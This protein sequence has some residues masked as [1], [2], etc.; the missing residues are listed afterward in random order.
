MSPM[1][2]AIDILQAETNIQMGWLLPTLTQLKAKLDRIK[3]SLKF[4]KPLVDAIQLGLKNR[5]SEI[6]EDPELIAAA[7]LL[8]KFKTLWTKDETVLKKGLDYINLELE[9]VHPLSNLQ[10]TSSDD[11]DFFS[12]IKSNAQESSK[13]LEGYLA[14]CA[15]HTSLLKTFPSLC[16]LF[17]RLNTPLPASAAL[18]GMPSQFF[19]LLQSEMSSLNFVEKLIV[20][21]N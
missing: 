20:K 9:S 10:A 17:I 21:M 3:P 13:E 1:A 12:S 16:K 19:E 6:L 8:P 4:S 14:C 11:D 5:F 7:I 2:K 15:D 18:E